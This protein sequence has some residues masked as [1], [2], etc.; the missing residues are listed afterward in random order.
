MPPFDFRA[1][2]IQTKQI[3]AT[4]SFD[5][6]GTRSQIAVYPIE[7]QGSPPNQGVI[8]SGLQEQLEGEDV[9]LFV[10]G[11]KDSKGD[12]TRGVV[13]FGGDIHISGNMTID[14]S[15]GGGGGGPSFVVTSASLGTPIITGDY[16]S[17]VITDV[18]GEFVGGLNNYIRFQTTNPVGMLIVV[19]P[20][21]YPV[22]PMPDKFSLNVQIF[23][24]D[25]PPVPFQSAVGFMNE[26]NT[27]AWQ[28]FHAIP[29][30]SISGSAVQVI[31][32]VDNVVG[33]MWNWPQALTNNSVDIVGQV[34]KIAP[35]AAIPQVKIDLDVGL[36]ESQ[37]PRTHGVAYPLGKTSGTL[38]SEWE[39]DDFHHP[40]IILI[41][42]T[43]VGMLDAYFSIEFLPHVK[44]R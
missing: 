9:F 16:G 5:G 8:D 12:S 36:F 44:D 2:S 22:A 26:D 25:N 29:T 10:S 23:T 6:T 4:G 30:G 35:F 18:P 41:Y 40:S 28:I 13:V 37:Y 32:V 34:E 7:A 11:A 39:G 42:P 21:E 33:A 27:K 1:S 38:N 14:G 24:G 43:Y 3:I 20:I 19:V 31:E 17:I 15:G